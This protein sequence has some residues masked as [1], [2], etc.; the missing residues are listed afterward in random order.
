MSFETLGLSPA[1]A[2]AVRSITP[3]HAIQP[4]R[5][6]LLAGR[7]YSRRQTGTGKRP[8][9]MRCFTHQRTHQR[10][11]IASSTRTDP[12][13]TRELAV[14]VHDS[15]RK[16]ANI[17]HA[18]TVV[19]GGAGMTRNRCMRRGVVILVAT[20]AVDRSSNRHLQL[21]TSQCWYS[22]KPIAC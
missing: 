9:C 22:M 19:Y 8:R 2:R 17:C 11:P 21:A 18:S 6:P 1:A 7:V 13:P 12:T 5:S 4:K 15:I 10:S 3:C 16:Y 20:P 14:Q